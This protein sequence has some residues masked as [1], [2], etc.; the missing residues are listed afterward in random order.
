MTSAF[1]SALVQQPLSPSTRLRLAD[2]TLWRALSHAPAPH[3]GSL[4]SPTSG[5]APSARAQLWAPAGAQSIVSPP[6]QQHA[7]PG[8]GGPV[9]AVRPSHAA[10]SPGAAAAVTPTARAAAAA[11][12]PTLRSS[13]L[14]GITAEFLNAVDPPLVSSA[15]SSAAVVS[16]WLR[17]HDDSIAVLF[18][19]DPAQ[20]AVVAACCSIACSAAGQRS[21]SGD[22]QLMVAHARSLSMRYAQHMHDELTEAWRCKVSLNSAQLLAAADCAELLVRSARPAAAVSAASSAAPSS[23]AMAMFLSKVMLS[24]QQPSEGSDLTSQFAIELVTA[25]GTLWRVDGASVRS[26]WKR[27][28]TSGEAA[29]VLVGTSSS[30][31][32]TSPA[33]P[34]EFELRCYG[35]A[36]A[37]TDYALVAR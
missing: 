37:D 25:A 19:V 5:P 20:V 15:H 3:S 8:S 12:A 2:Q 27:P 23:L 28:E 35:V 26:K 22:L 11:A 4:L 13:P 6:V 29:Q 1:N 33:L 30:A 17:S 32:A 7:A 34:D 16:S 21:E 14:Y 9:V 24:W 31:M 10:S 36:G 18:G